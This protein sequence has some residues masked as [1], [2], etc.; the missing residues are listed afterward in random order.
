MDYRLSYISFGA[1]K[2]TSP[3]GTRTEYEKYVVPYACTCRDG[4][5]RFGTVS[6]VTEKSNGSKRPVSISTAGT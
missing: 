6:T 2:Q 1:E 4:R 3:I 5:E